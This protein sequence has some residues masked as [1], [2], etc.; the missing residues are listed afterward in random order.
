MIETFQKLLEILPKSDRWKFVALFVLMMIGTALEVAGIGM[1]PVFISAVAD[2][3]LVLEH[4]WLGEIAKYLGITTGEE[5][6]LYGGIFLV[7]IFLVKGVYLVWFNYIKSKFI[8]NRF[9]KIA[10]RL[11]ETYLSAPYTLHLNRNTAELI[12]NVTNETR[13]ISNN[14]MMPAMNVLKDSV[15]IVGIFVLLLFSEPLITV[16]TFSV[17]GG[18]GGLMIKFL[19]EKLRKYG[20]IASRERSRMIQGV[21]EGLGGFKDVTVMNR[22]KMFFNKFKEYVNNLTEAEIFKGTAKASSKPIIEF[23]SVFG[24]IFIAFAMIWQDRPISTVVPVLTLFGAATVRLMPAVNRVVNQL[25]GLRYYIHALSPVHA[26]LTSMEEYYLETKESSNNNEKLKFNN[27]IIVKDLWYKYPNTED[28]VLKD[29]NIKVPKNSAIGFVGSTGAGKSTIVDVILGL[30]SPDKGKVIVDETDISENKRAWQNNVGYIPQFIYLSD[31]TI[32]HNIAFGIPEELISEK[33]INA[34]I[35]A[36]QLE[37]FIQDLPEGIDTVVGEEGVRLSGGQKQRIGIARALYDNPDVLIMDEATSSLDNVTE[38]K[39]ISAIEA[40]KGERTI[41]MIAHR[42]TTVENCDVL[43]MMKD[44]KVI[45]KGTY[46]ELLESSY[47]FQK[48][49]LA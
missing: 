9:G 32:R 25:T 46:D 45:E 27:S 22:K 8:Y 35:E 18:G 42:L 43:Y 49:K 47:D 3:D 15:T 48:M 4:Q 28:F 39:V 20:V 36:A 7:V 23:A 33:K 34:A 24:M 12:R 19:R 37:D 41:I 5:L 2:P 6:L 17:I 44:G 11:F 26:D 29:I 21:N 10:S 40:L 38:R 1:I 30:L 13:Y 31:D 16:I 14:V